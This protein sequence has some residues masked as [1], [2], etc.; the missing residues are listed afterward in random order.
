MCSVFEIESRKQFRNPSYLKH[1]SEV[2]VETISTVFKN[3]QYT[4][5]W[6]RFIGAVAYQP[7]TFNSQLCVLIPVAAIRCIIS[8]AKVKS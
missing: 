7:E 5:K 2:K 8:A 1:F 6:L 4:L 3:S